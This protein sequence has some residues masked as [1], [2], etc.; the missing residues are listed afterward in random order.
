MYSRLSANPE[1]RLVQPSTGYYK[2]F[3]YLNAR[4]PY[5]WESDNGGS[6]RLLLRTPETR[7]FLVRSK[8]GGRFALAE[9]FFPGWQATVDGIAAPIERWRGTFQAVQ[10]AAGEH[11][12]EFR[13][14]SRALVLGA[15]ISL[16]AILLIWVG[17]SLGPKRNALRR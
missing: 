16:A 5:G 14:R 13:Y 2:V 8:T 11:R 1:F 15:W 7:T 10:V 4:P 6:A 17:F 9:Q 3:E 12:V